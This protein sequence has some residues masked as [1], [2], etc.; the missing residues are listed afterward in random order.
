MAEPTSSSATPPGSW[1]GSRL[2]WGLI[3]VGMALL[4]SSH[5]PTMLD[6]LAQCRQ[7]LTLQNLKVLGLLFAFSV[8]PII[9]LWR[10]SAALALPRFFA[11]LYLLFPI[12]TVTVYLLKPV[13]D[14]LRTRG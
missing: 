6:Q 11:F 1:G 2:S 7:S 5:A 12:A 8:L 14:R 4:L 10:L 3:I 9:G 13:L